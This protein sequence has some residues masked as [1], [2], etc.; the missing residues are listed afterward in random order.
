MSWRLAT[1]LIA[2]GV[3]AISCH[4]ALS[5]DDLELVDGNG[6]GGGSSTSTSTSTSGIG[7]TGGIGGIGGIGGAGGQGGTGG[8]PCDPSLCPGADTDCSKRICDDN[9]ECDVEHEP[10]GTS[11]TGSGDERVCDGEGTCVECMVTDDCDGSDLCD[12]Q[13][14]VPPTCTDQQLNGTETDVDCGGDDCAP[15]A[16]TEGCLV[17][18]DCQSGFCDSLFCAPCADENDCQGAEYCDTQVCQ[19]QKA[20]GIGC[21]ADI[22]CLNGHCPGQDQVCCDT[23]CN[24]TCEACQA[25]KT[26][27]TDGTCALVTATDDFDG[28]C[29]DQGA[30]SCGSDG[31]G[32][33]GNAPECILYDNQTSC[34]PPTCSNNTEQPESFCDGSGTCNTPGTNPCSPYTCDGNGT[35]CRTDC[36]VP[37]DCTS[38]NTCLIGS[39]STGICGTPQALGDP[40]AFDFEC[41]NNTCRDGVCCDGNCAGTCRSCLMAET[42]LPANGMCGDILDGQDPLSECQSPSGDVCNGQGGCR[43]ND[44][45]HNGDESDTDCGGSICDYCPVGATCTAASDCVNG[46]CPAQ[47]GVCCDAPCTGLCE[48]CL[49][50]KSTASADGICSPMTPGQ[51]YDNECTADQAN[52]VAAYCDGVPGQCGVAQSNVTCRQATLPC[53]VAEVCDGMNVGCPQDL[54]VPLNPPQTCRAGTHPACDPAEICD[55]TN[56]TCPNDFVA[57]SGVPCPNSQFC[58]GAETCDGAGACQAS[59][60]PCPGPDGDSDCSE[61]CHEPSAACIANDPNN[62]Q[63][64]SGYSCHEGVC[65]GFKPTPPGGTCPGACN[66]G[67]NGGVCTIA[68]WGTSSCAGNVLSCPQGWACE[69]DCSGEG[70]CDQVTLACPNDYECTAFCSNTDACTNLSMLCSA[71]GSCGIDCS[72]DNGSCDGALVD[73]GLNTCTATCAGASAPSLNCSNSCSCSGC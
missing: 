20:D 71:S 37:T 19:P 9:D 8:D 30:A 60:D 51:N 16:N 21:S 14:C 41:Q 57:A 18:G 29:N 50:W 25:A 70:S 13:M 15:C 1:T 56:K 26:G 65:C 2:T 32:C 58:D 22:E 39:Q 23:A 27:G 48:A 11:C 54:V 64:G 52:C 44:T 31:T 36:T 35:A 66:G 5:L 10:A 6:G 45:I 69:L 49:A 33:S 40:C 61:S 3:L 62:S 28:E 59:V 4:A 38:G 43:C 53:D 67:C 72:P 47:D 68:C 73:C 46:N 17:A 42:G 63:C 24:A 7:G 55:G 12:N 34:A